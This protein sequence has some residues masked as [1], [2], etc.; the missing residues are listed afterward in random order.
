MEKLRNEITRTPALK[1]L[2]AIATS[3]L[4]IDLSACRLGVWCGVVLYGPVCV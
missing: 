2:A 1:A 4:K 3:P